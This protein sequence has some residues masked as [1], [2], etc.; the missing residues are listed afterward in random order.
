MSP[1]ISTEKGFTL[2]ELL[3]VIAI[4][5]TLAALLLPALSKAKAKAYRVQCISNLKQIALGSHLYTDD[6]DGRFAGNGYL[7]TPPNGSVR[8]WAMGLQHFNMEAFHNSSYLIDPKFSQFADYIHAGGVYRCP[9]DKTLLTHAG[10]SAPRVRTYSLNSYFNWGTPASDD[11]IEPNYV[12]FQKTSDLAYV[13]PSDTFTFIDTA[14]LIVCNAGFKVYQ[15]RGIF[16]HR[17]SVEHENIGVL[18]F[19]DGRVDVQHWRDPETIRLAHD[20]GGS[21]DGNHLVFGQGGNI[22][23]KWIREHSTRLKP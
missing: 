11:V 5:A 6:N 15:T 4:I 22:D 12:L 14:P 10:V 8:F 1:H 21:G 20:A 7:T 23:L 16:Y 9:A 3:V 13:N 17:P 18:A 19:A 2:I